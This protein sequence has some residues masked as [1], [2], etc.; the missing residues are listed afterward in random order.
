[1]RPDGTYVY[2]P[3]KGFKG[4]DKFTY[5]IKDL[6]GRIVTATETIRIAP[7]SIVLQCLTTFGNFSGLIIKK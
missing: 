4:T 1:M 6:T 5:Q 3:D 7:R 2:K